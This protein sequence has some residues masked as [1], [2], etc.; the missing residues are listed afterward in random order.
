MSRLHFLRRKKGFTLIEMLIVLI[1]VALLMA[2]IIPNVAGQKTR[3]EKQARVNI[4]QIIETQ[5][6][7][8]QLAENDKDVT[9]KELADKGYLTTKQVDEAKKL[10]NLTDDAAIT[11]PIP[12]PDK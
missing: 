5:V 1:I 9:I 10:L 6:N 12:V 11:V 4:A 7:T 2:I 3:I 8:Y